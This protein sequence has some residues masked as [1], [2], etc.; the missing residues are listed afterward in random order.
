MDY[1]MIP[2]MRWFGPN[3]PVKLSD[4][5]QAGC[6]GI[7]TALHHI[8]NGVVWEIEEIQKRKD[9]IQ[10][11]GMVW[12]VVE[13]LPVSED[14]KTRSGNY[15]QQLE[16]YKQ[17]II[18]LASCGVNIITYNFM[19]IL[20]WTRTN[21]AYEL[22]NGAKALYF[23]KLALVVF[24]LFILER[25]NAQLDYTSEEV[26]RATQKFAAMSQAEKDKL[27]ATIIA[28]LP[29]SEEGYS[30]QKFRSAL[31]TYKGIDADKLRANLVYFLEQIIPTA[32]A[33]G[34]K[35]V[36]HPDDPPYPILGLPRVVSKTSDYEHIISHVPSKNNGI[37]FCTGSLG[38]SPDN[39]LPAMIKQFG[40]RIYFL[41]L[42]NTR[43]NELG[44]FYED[45]HLDGNA[46]MYAVVKEVVLCMQKNKIS[47]P[48][49]PDHGHQMLDDLGKV[50]NPGYSAIG[51][52]KGLAELR[53]LE[54]G[55]IR[56]LETN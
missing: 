4:I 39:D 40:D 18:N 17:S 11:H 14:I 10:A 30:I 8:P 21:L 38:V 25:E 33:H 27:Q 31:A 45:N 15:I 16:N 1:K 44:D 37:C 9:E 34:V 42:R 26:E 23:E 3:D 47:I 41:H 52:L 5:R 56:N 7:V 48:V 43:R 19:P 12:N 20:D 50:V 35:M 28:G 13:S 49:R 46:D 53:G 32:E 55:I 6:E 24:D 51:R 29:G 36:V 22:E 2:T 54:Y